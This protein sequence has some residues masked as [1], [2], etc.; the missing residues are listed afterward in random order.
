MYTRF[1]ICITVI[2]PWCYHVV[3]TARGDY[4]H[5]NT[6]KHILFI[7]GILEMSC[8]A[9]ARLGR[10]VECCWWMWSVNAE[11]F[12]LLLFFFI[13]KKT[14]CF[15]NTLCGNCLVD[16]STCTCTMFAFFKSNVTLDDKMLGVKVSLLIIM[17]AFSKS[18]P[19]QTKLCQKLSF[20]TIFFPI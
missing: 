15:V 2:A 20:Q 12:V 19:R 18:Y 6:D 11:S 9:L 5:L 14:D 16:V 7:I 10:T 17:Y 8:L 1:P 3:Y 13:I 4:H